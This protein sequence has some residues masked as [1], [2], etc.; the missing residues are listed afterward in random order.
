MLVS[1]L[2]GTKETAI[3]E[4]PPMLKMHGVQHCTADA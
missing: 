4:K 1:W 3:E 2:G